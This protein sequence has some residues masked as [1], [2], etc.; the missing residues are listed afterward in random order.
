M[1]STLFPSLSFTTICHVHLS[2]WTWFIEPN[3]LHILLCRAFAGCVIRG[4]QVHC[5][6]YFTSSPPWLH[7]PCFGRAASWGNQS[8]PDQTYMNG[9]FGRINSPSMNSYFGYLGT[10]PC[11]KS[12]L[13]SLGFS[14]W[15]KSD[16]PSQEWHQTTMKFQPHFDPQ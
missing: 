9:Y 8:D 15:Y 16:N 13:P 11:C 12:K 14:E 7:P 6:I 5:P 4:N 1:S 10:I 2:W 3:G